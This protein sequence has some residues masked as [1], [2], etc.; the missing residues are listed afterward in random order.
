MTSVLRLRRLAQ[1]INL[2]EYL[3]S[4]AYLSGKQ[5][6]DECTQEMPCCDEML[7]RRWVRTQKQLFAHPYAQFGSAKRRAVAKM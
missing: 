6:Y 1:G 3:P 7:R 2:N 4:V 5:I